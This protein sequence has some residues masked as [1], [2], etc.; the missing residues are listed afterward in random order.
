MRGE[1]YKWRRR[2]ALRRTARNMPRVLGHGKQRYVRLRRVGLITVVAVVCAVPPVGFATAVN[3]RYEFVGLRPYRCT[4]ASG[5]IPWDSMAEVGLD[6]RVAYDGVDAPG[7]ALAEVKQRDSNLVAARLSSTRTNAD[8][9]IA[10]WRQNQWNG[11]TR[12]V[13]QLARRWSRV[14]A[15][16]ADDGG[17]EAKVVARCLANDRYP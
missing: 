12:A 10:V 8:L 17:T 5:S 7:G 6:E 3:A 1:V 4:F 15:P 16:I 13:N 2:R 9:G 14:D 11:D